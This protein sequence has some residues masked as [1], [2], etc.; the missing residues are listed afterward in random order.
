MKLPY[1]LKRS[2]ITE[3]SMSGAAQN[4]YSFEVDVIASKGQIKKAVE[5]TFDVQVIS[6]RTAKMAGKRYRAGK[7]RREVRKPDKKKAIVELKQGQKIDM[8]ETQT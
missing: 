3:K 8:F 7:S 2:I 1:I 5:D 6:V 4:R